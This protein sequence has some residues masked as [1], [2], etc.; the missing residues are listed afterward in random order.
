MYYRHVCFAKQKMFFLLVIVICL[1]ILQTETL[2]LSLLQCHHSTNELKFSFVR[3]CDWPGWVYGN[4]NGGD[5][6]SVERTVLE[7][8]FYLPQIN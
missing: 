6:S 5:I 4:T 3:V 7:H 2:S 8:F 1:L